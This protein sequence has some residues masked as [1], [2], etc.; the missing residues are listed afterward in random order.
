[1]SETGNTTGKGKSAV[2]SD[3]EM[4]AMADSIAEAS[5]NVQDQMN[6]CETG[7]ALIAASNEMAQSDEMMQLLAAIDDTSNS[8]Y[9]F[10][11]GRYLGEFMQKDPDK[12][13]RKYA[14]YL[15]SLINDPKYQAMKDYY[16]KIR[17][18]ALKL[19]TSEKYRAFV[20]C[21][22]AFQEDESDEAMEIKN[23]IME[24]MATQQE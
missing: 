2:P 1:M 21:N 10:T 16:A 8:K 7:K 23:N 14:K 18:N 9:A 13:L 24:F 6:R 3:E 22:T 12:G 15:L 5:R 17:E 11:L 4:A 19:D 20:A